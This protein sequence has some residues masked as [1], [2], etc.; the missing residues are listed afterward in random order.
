MKKYGLIGKTLKHSWSPQWFNKMFADNKIE[1]EYQLYELPELGD[2]HRW[3]NHLELDGFSVTI[4][5][6]ESIIPQLD[7]IDSHAQAIGA[8]NCVEVNNGKLIGHN[9]DAPAFAE[10]LKPLLKPWHTNGLI[11]GTGGASKAV[12]NALKELGIDYKFVSR[13]GPTLPNTISYNDAFALAKE[14]YLIVN[15]TPL[16]MFPNNALTPWTDVHMLG[17]KHLCYDLIYNPEE[18]RF[19]LDSELCGANVQGGLPM[20]HRQAELAWAI[21]SKC[22]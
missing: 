16:G 15:T 9:T 2:L 11:L 5:Y 22:L 13:K 7:E 20:L 19:M 6:K 4:P 14:W 3:A 18:T 8:V 17:A 1:A 12:S 10:T 21:W